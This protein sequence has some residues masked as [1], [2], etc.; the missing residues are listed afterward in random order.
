M[1]TL[2]L[3]RRYQR[4]CTACGY[5]WVVTRGEAQYRARPHVARN[6]RGLPASGMQPYYRDAAIGGVRQDV[7]QQVELAQQF[8]RC[9]RC[10]STS[11][12]QRPVTRRRPPD[13]APGS[14]IEPT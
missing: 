11:F 1:L 2:A 14:P 6:L 12:S 7:E 4:T 9:A 10:G 5:A 8:T 3:H 13:T